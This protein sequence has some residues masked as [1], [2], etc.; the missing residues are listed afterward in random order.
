[1]EGRKKTQWRNFHCHG[2]R[3]ARYSHHSYLTEGPFPLPLLLFLLP[4]QGCKNIKPDPTGSIQSNLKQSPKPQHSF[5]LLPL[6][7]L[8]L[9]TSIS[10]N[11]LNLHPTG[12]QICQRIPLVNTPG[13]DHCQERDRRATEPDVN[14]VFE[15]REDVTDYESQCLKRERERCS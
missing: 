1:M 8:L 12:R 9:T 14:G 3:S 5:D 10:I 6:I 13:R 4:S 2:P 15:V 7:L 11:H